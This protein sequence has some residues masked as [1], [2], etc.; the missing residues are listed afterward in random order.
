MRSLNWAT[1][2]LVSHCSSG[3]VAVK[4][5]IAMASTCDATANEKRS[6]ISEKIRRMRE[7][8]YFIGI[9]SIDDIE[10]AVAGERSSEADEKAFSDL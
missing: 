6:E 7:V 10:K 9:M 5:W 3:L 2:V 4:H 8:P 1:L